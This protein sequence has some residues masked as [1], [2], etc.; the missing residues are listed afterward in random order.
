VYGYSDAP[1]RVNASNQ[2]V[3][4]AGEAA[5]SAAEPRALLSQASQLV[6]GGPL[7]RMTILAARPDTIVVQADYYSPDEAAPLE[8]RRPALAHATSLAL[9]ANDE[10]VVETNSATLSRPGALMSYLNPI[11]YYAR[12]QRA[13]D[14][15]PRAALLNVHA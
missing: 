4:L 5:P 3:I 2:S 12:A 7:K 10:V 14:A 13:F 11:D 6:A 1:V 8:S 15:P 9:A